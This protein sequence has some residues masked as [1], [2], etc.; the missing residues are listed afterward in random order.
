MHAKSGLRGVLKWKIFR[1]D[2]V[3][4]DVI[5]L[6]FPI[7]T[8]TSIHG[9]LATPLLFA[10]CQESGSGHSANNS[11]EEPGKQSEPTY[12]SPST[13]DEPKAQRMYGIIGKLNATDG[14]REK[15][16]EI[17]L[18]GAQEMPG[19]KLYAISAD[20]ED[21]NAIWITEIWDSEESHQE[22]LQLPAVQNAIATGK[23][24]IAGFGE[25]HVVTPIGGVGVD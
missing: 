2:S 10:G 18:A 21:A 8:T 13:I 6:G 23:P 16:I 15:L 7:E 14:N 20:S 22:S 1:P 24:M 17:L 25:R 3:I 9:C 19:C 4:A 5:H 12:D 11:C